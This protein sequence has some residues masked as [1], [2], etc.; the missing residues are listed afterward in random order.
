M[1]GYFF[2]QRKICPNLT[3]IKT[4][5]QNQKY[6]G[7]LLKGIYQEKKAFHHKIFCGPVFF[8]MFFSAPFRLLFVRTIDILLGCRSGSQ[9]PFRA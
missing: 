1:G 8:L 9:T 4:F 2:S 3:I 7:H 5:F 6:F